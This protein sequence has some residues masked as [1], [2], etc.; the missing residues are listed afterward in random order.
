MTKKGHKLRPVDRVAPGSSTKTSQRNPGRY[1][2]TKATTPSPFEA[3]PLARNMSDRPVLPPMLDPL[4]DV[5]EGRRLLRSLCIDGAVSFE[6]L[7]V[8]AMKCEDAVAKGAV[9][10][11]G[12][13]NPK[14]NTSS[15]APAWETP[16]V[17]TR[18]SGSRD[19]RSCRSRHTQINRHP[20]WIRRRIR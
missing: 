11:G 15:G 19:R 2:S 9:F 14:G 8:G 3:A 16:E 12:M 1:L 6:K 18:R 17:Q 10:L 5:E 20:A 13:S 7:P 4:T